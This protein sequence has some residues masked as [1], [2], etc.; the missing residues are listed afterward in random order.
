MITVGWKYFTGCLPLLHAGICAVFLTWGCGGPLPWRPDRQE[1]TAEVQR[2]QATRYFVKAKVFEAQKNYHGAIV[3]LRSAA[4]L[5]PS[6]PTIHERL[7]LA[8]EKIDDG[9]MAEIFARKALKL[10]PG[11]TKLRY[12]LFRIFQDREDEHRAARELERLLPYEPTNWQLYFHLTDFYLKTGQIRRISPLLEPVLKRDDAPPGVRVNIGYVYLHIGD[13][14]KAEDIF[15]RVLESHP[16]IE[17]AWLGMAAVQISGGRREAG[18]MYYRQA[19]RILPE[20]PVFF[21]KL[22]VLVAAGEE[23]NTVLA[24]EGP[25]F[26]YRLG[27]AL[28]EA[29]RYAEAA[30]V[31]EYIVEMQPGT[32]EEWLDL[33]RYFIVREE[34]DRANEILSEAAA[35]MPDSSSIYLFWGA[36]MER[37]DRFERAIDIYRRGLEVHPDEI[38]FYL[39]WGFA[40]EKQK[41]WTEAIAVYD[42]ALELNS[43]HAGLHMRR[44]IVLGRRQQ[45]EEAILQ[46]R[47][48]VKLDSLNGDLYLHWGLALEKLEL[49]E[50]AIEK[51]ILATDLDPEDTHRLFYLGSCF[52]QAARQ[53]G[54]EAYFD[55]AIETFERLLEADP[56]DAYSLNYLGYM[57]ADKGI[58]LEE[59]VVMLSK[60]VSLDPGNSAFLD[61]LGWA[62]FR[63]GQLDHAQHYL[64]RALEILGRGD[65]TVEAAGDQ[66]IIL[67]HAG[68]VAQALGKDNEAR[69]HWTRAL[70]LAPD[71]H[72]V[73]TKLE[74]ILP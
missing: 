62:Y 46:Y 13:R 17:S 68:D 49:W 69:T 21:H 59:A 7:A 8:Y 3:A 67:D 53:T 29:Q 27:L 56:D 39:Y 61:S 34:Y 66:A 50:E 74:L 65:P 51:L 42:R 6:S 71:N 25:R 60:A 2:K 43:G 4:D 23:L 55:R 30:A 38:D 1:D 40:H 22:A 20:S 10:D 52:E 44:G 11:R 45:W 72:D 41:N 14:K 64:G 63:L 16:E 36:A 9:R 24:E 19:A 12:L 15:E 33:A 37:A 47:N 57:Y 31:F 5:D 70:E 26:L 35:A 18:L 48:A 32:A 28:S 54:R 73:K 58:H